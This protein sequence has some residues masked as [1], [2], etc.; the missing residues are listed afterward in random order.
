[1]ARNWFYSRDSDAEIW[2]R[3]HKFVSVSPPSAFGSVLRRTL[4][5]SARADSQSSEL[6]CP[7]E[8][9]RAHERHVLESIVNL[10]EA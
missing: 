6:G 4:L 1:M 2:L 8:A 3:H 5:G 9:L 7:Y 10:P